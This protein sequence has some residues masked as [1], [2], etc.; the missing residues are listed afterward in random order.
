MEP[1]TE[2]SGREGLLVGLSGSESVR[3]GRALRE[4]IASYD[5]SLA[6]PLRRWE[7]EQA[8]ER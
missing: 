2:P 8:G 1:F 6:E 3:V 7:I 4:L 5:S